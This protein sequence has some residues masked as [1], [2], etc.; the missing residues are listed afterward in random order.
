M[1]NLIEHLPQLVDYTTLVY[2]EAR[3]VRHLIDAQAVEPEKWD[4]LRSLLPRNK[5]EAWEKLQDIRSKAQQAKSVQTALL[6]F[7]QRFNVTLAQLQELFDNPAWRHARLYGGNA[8][9]EI[10]RLVLCL[11]IAL[12]KENYNEVNKILEKLSQA[13]HNTGSLSAKL[14][15]LDDGL[16]PTRHIDS[17]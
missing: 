17:I 10:T 3:N 12:E 6:L 8:W 5:N 2:H 4:R 14:R 15:Q 7:E 13:E 9:K 16:V 11:T 1:N